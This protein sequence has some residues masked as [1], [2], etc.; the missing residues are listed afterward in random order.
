T[1]RSSGKMGYMIAQAAQEAGARVNLISG[2]T[3]LDSPYGVA[4]MTVQTAQE[5]QKTVQATIPG[6]DVFIAVAAVSDWR[7]AN[8]SGQKLKRGDGTAAPALQFVANPDILAEVAGL[9]DAPYC[10]GFAAETEQ[11]HKYA[12]EKRQR[13]GVPLLVGN[14]VQ[15]AMDQDTTELV[16]FDDQ[17]HETLARQSKRRAA[18]ALIQRI[19]QR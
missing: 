2:P 18:R 13:K 11:L 19:A 7:I 14:L 8:V 5:M 1:N 17:G 12:Q 15:D 9:P 10:V 3:A 4:R 6:S 16:I